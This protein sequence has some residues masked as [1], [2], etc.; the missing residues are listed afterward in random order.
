MASVAASA[1]FSY[2]DAENDVAAKYQFYDATTGRG[3][4]E[5]NGQ[6]Q[7]ENQPI[8]VTAA[9]LS[10]T[11]FQ[12]GSG[13]DTLYVRVFDGFD[14]GT[15]TS[16]QFNAPINNAPVVSSNNTSLA[17]GSTIAAD[18]LITTID[19]END[20]FT[21]FQ[22]YDAT[23]GASTGHFTI[24]GIVQPATQIIDVLAEQMEDTNFHAGTAAGTDQLYARAFDGFDWSEWHA[25]IATT[26]A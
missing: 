8:D 22:F 11:S 12:G 15:W 10:Q 7:G 6:V 13:S 19:A 18:A 16:F 9:Q 4:F 3:H 17:I 5:I 14:W 26:I 24:D 20:S 21:R 1:L 25:F 23:V 2:A